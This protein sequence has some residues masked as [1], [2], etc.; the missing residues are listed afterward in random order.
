MTQE[1]AAKVL[2]TATGK[3]TGY[4]A[5]VTIGSYKQ[6]ATHAASE[7]GDLACGNRPRKDV[8]VTHVSDDLGVT[9][10]RA[11]RAQLGLDQPAEAHGRLAALF[12]VAITLGLRPGELRALRWDHVD[13]DQG[14]VYVWRSTRRDGDTK[15]PKS[16]RSLMLPKRA[17]E[18][19]KAHKQ[20]QAAERLAAGEDWQDYG[21]VFCNTDGAPYTRDALNWRF[22]RITRQAGIGHWHAHEGRHTAVSIMSN[23]GVPIQDISD[24]MG[25]KSTHVTE[26]VYRHVIVPA[27]RG[28]A[29]VMDDVFG[30][31]GT[32]SL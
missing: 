7:A 24:T 14:I 19:L 26:T 25:H 23:N 15:T 12:V 22:G 9:T 10:C 5:V 2:N 31:T 29:S 16:R 13:L 18:A 6:A 27:I 21:L 30:D 20:H 4:V 32:G 11:C 17:L 8:K 3:P 28:G 1:Q